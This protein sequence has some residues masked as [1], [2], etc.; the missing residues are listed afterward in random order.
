MSRWAEDRS[1]AV[2]VIRLGS[3]TIKRL[4]V[5]EKGKPI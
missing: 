5:E 2:V 4:A 3:S 1:L